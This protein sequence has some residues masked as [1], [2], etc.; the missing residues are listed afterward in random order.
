MSEPFAE[1]NQKD[2]ILPAQDIDDY[3][4]PMDLVLETPEQKVEEHVEHVVIIVHGIRDNGFWTKRVAKELKTLARVE[5]ISL[6]APTPSYGYFSMWDFVRLVVKLKP[7]AGLW[8]NTQMLKVISPMRR[9][10][11]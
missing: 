3:L 4:D 9:L 6:R 8:R 7:H 11:L 1:L 10:V 5:Q 2:W